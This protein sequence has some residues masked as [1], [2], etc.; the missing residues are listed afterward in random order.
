M[1]LERETGIEPANGAA[2]STSR[3]GVF[4]FLKTDWCLGLEAQCLPLLISLLAGEAE[5]FGRERGSDSNSRAG[6]PVGAANSR[7]FQSCRMPFR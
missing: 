3:D 4:R 6:S 1:C 2:C 5:V 7:L